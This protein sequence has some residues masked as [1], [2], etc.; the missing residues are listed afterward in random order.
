M[1]FTEPSELIKLV[2]SRRS[3]TQNR[4]AKLIGKSQAQVSKYVSGTSVPSKDT[5]IHLMN[6]ISES[7][8]G[9]INPLDIFLQIHQ[10]DPDRHR[11]FLTAL[12]AMVK[13]YK[14]V[15]KN[16]SPTDVSKHIQKLG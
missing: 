1:L 7:D 10:L 14:S 11:D 8:A 5:I 9:H 6:I 12:M 2:M 15:L 3:M 13:A 4:I 16:G